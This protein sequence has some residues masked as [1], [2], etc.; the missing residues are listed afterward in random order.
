MARIRGAID[1]ADR[2]S[3]PCRL[4]PPAVR[5]L[6][7]KAAARNPPLCN[8]RGF[9]TEEK[10]EPGQCSS[11]NGERTRLR[12]PGR[13]FVHE[14]RPIGGAQPV[15]GIIEHGGK[16]RVGQVHAVDGRAID[17]EHRRS[18]IC[19]PKDAVEPD[20]ALVE[21]TDNGGIRYGRPG[22]GQPDQFIVT[23]SRID[24]GKV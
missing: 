8:R 2:G 14:G 21:I 4:R 23:V 13:R 6:V 22:E 12:N 24:P 9:T 7:R 1:R 15:P 17:G 5:Y 19:Q 18:V 16:C 11:Q 3:W 20:R 10:P